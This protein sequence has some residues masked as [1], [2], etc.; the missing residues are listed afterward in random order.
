MPYTT[1]TPS[2]EY[3]TPR[4][5]QWLTKAIGTVRRVSNKASMQR[6]RSA[7]GVL[8]PVEE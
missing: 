6:A 3:R 2:R 1:T 7:N 8:T 5:G 4:E